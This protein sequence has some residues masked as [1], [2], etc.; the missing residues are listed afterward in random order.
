MTH[1][2]AHMQMLTDSCG[3]ILYAHTQAIIFAPPRRTD[4][5]VVVG[6]GRERRR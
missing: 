3:R 4:R 6:G 1:T 5:V 2:V